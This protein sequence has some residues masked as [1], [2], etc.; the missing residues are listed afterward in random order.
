MR[1]RIHR[2]QM[3]ELEELRNGLLN[4]IASARRPYSIAPASQAIMLERLLMQTISEQ[5]REERA[6]WKDMAEVQREFLETAFAYQASRQRREL[7]GGLE[8]SYG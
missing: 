6:Y 4:H 3:Q 1:Q 8:R 5:Q 2:E 7:L